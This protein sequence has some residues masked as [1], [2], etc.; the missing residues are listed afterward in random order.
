VLLDSV[1]DVAG[2]RSARAAIDEARRSAGRPGRPQVTV[3]VEVD[4]HSPAQVREAV[5]K[6]GEAGADTVVLQGTHEHP[7][8]EPIIAALA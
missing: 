6:F 4:P 8:P 5:E 7:E 3:F 1:V 2:V